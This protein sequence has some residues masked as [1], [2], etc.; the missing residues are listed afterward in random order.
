MRA[1]WGLWRVPGRGSQDRVSC[2]RCLRPYYFSSYVLNM[3]GCLLLFGKAPHK[4]IEVLRDPLIHIVIVH[5]PEQLA[6]PCLGF[7]TQADVGFMRVPDH[8]ILRLRLVRIG[9]AWFKI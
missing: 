3:W 8:G 7:P 9:L 5:P 4:V 6:D 1:G 2:V